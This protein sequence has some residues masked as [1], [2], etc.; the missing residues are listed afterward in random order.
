MEVERFAGMECSI[1]RTLAIVG[2][3]WTMLVLRD[4]FNG[5]RRFD[6]FLASLGIAR[7]ILA[8]RLH[9]LVEHGILE[10]RPYQQRPVRHEYR[11]TEKGRDLFP[12]LIAL[13]QWGDRYL[14]GAAGPPYIVS[15]RACGHEAIPAVLCPAC[16]DL[17]TA[18]DTLRTA[19]PGLTRG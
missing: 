6:D 15:H 16:G 19:G 3:R 18:R 7:N 1:A 17:L 8:D 4:A 11:L 10:R 5:V 14:A 9:T 12:V 2:E 13:M